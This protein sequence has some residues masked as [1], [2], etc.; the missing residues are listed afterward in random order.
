MSIKKVNLLQGHNNYFYKRKIANFSEKCN[1]YFKRE[2]ILTKANYNYTCNDSTL[3][4]Q[5]SI[6]GNRLPQIN[7]LKRFSKYYSSIFGKKVSEEKA[8]EKMNLYQKLSYIKE[9]EE[10]CKKAFEQIKNDFGYKDINIPLVLDKNIK[11]DASWNS[12]ECRMSIFCDNSM[13]LDG[14]KKIGIIKYLLH[15]FRHVKQTELAYR[16]SPDKLLDAMDEN[17]TRRTIG[18]IIEQ[19][20]IAQQLIKQGLVK[21]LE[22]FQQLFRKMGLKEKV[23]DKIYMNGRKVVFDK[24]RARVMLDKTFGDLEPLKKGSLKYKKGL[25]FIEGER[26]YIPYSIDE[27]KYKNG[28]LEKDA[29][30]TGRKW[31]S[32]ID[33]T[34]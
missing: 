30:K 18:W 2:K 6:F 12:A 22:D 26:T 4:Y 16:T 7:F 19:P 27:N 11:S 28:I 1:E 20:D 8:I 5:D 32:I 33:L 23:D 17:Y 9:P 10:F 3:T 14:L 13:K 21:S 29:F 24:E 34:I 15:E 31:H 25:R